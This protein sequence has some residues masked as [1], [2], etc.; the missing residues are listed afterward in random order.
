MFGQKMDVGSATPGGVSV[1]GIRRT[2]A[3]ALTTTGAPTLD[4][5]LYLA[6]TFAKALLIGGN[7]RPCTLDFCIACG[8]FLTISLA[9]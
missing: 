4:L 5:E 1:S 7:Q 3:L 2:I 9:N 8:K 6:F